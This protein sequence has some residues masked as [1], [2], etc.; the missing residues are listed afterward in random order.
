VGRHAQGVGRL[1]QSLVRIA[2]TLVLTLGTA[3][4]LLAQTVVVVGAEGRQGAHFQALR[5]D[6]TPF[7]SEELRGKTVLLDF[8]GTWCPPCIS[9]FPK[10]SRIQADL[11][12]AKFQVLG[13]AF[14]SGTPEEVA[15]FVTGYDVRYPVVVIDD[16]VADVFE[17]E[18]F[19]TYVLIGPD[20][21]EID[22][23]EGPH[24][25]LH[26]RV[27]EHLAETN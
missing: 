2:V 15:E 11:G 27:A 20:G 18:L 8:W 13:L 9:A 22:R 6:G 12:D 19:P 5:L 23:F 10:L 21:S 4:A 1:G 26:R 24:T 17:I 16:P 3:G 25:D 7:D 14:E